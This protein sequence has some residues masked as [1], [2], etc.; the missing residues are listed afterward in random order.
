MTQAAKEV[1]TTKADHTPERTCIGC[2]G[3]EP[4]AL[5]ARYVVRMEGEVAIIE[6]DSAGS[7]PGR[8]AYVHRGEDCLATA[9]KRRAFRRAL[10]IPAGIPAELLHEDQ[11]LQEGTSM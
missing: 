6:H 8:G 9:V 3:R 7:S 2:R 5:L 11:R 4:K 1:R 10:R